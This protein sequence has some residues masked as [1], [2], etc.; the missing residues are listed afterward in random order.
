MINEDIMPGYA[1]VLVAML[2]AGAVVRPA[3]GAAA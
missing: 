1:L 2:L 3:D